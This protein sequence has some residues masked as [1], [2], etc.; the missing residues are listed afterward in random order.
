MSAAWHEPVTTSGVSSVSSMARR[1]RA[2]S[3]GR[4]SAARRHPTCTP[5]PIVPKPANHAKRRSRISFL[6]LPTALELWSALFRASKRFEVGIDE[7]RYRPACDRTSCKDSA[8][9]V[10]GRLAAPFSDSVKR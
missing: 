9:N 4:L 3:F 5:R 1:G 6:Y 2:A 7:D 8:T 10:G